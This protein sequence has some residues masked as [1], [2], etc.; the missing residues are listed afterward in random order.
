MKIQ[1]SPFICC[2]ACLL[3]I[4]CK[5]LSIR[6]SS[7][8][9]TQEVKIDK[10]AGDLDLAVHILATLIKEGVWLVTKIPDFPSERDRYDSMEEFVQAHADYLDY[11]KYQ[12][13]VV[14]SALKKRNNSKNANV[15]K[16]LAIM[17]RLD[18]KEMDQLSLSCDVALWNYR[19]KALPHVDGLPR[20]KL[21]NSAQALTRELEKAKK[22]YQKILRKRKKTALR[23]KSRG[24]TD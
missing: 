2:L 8:Y 15:S 4:S 21:E 14:A 3:P 22:E 9:V 19:R 20:E 1:Y 5:S 16:E 12:C 11:K 10:N 17:D 18:I 6:E 7:E 24:M 23:Q 13:E